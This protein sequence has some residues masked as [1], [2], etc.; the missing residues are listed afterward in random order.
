MKKQNSTTFIK[1]LNFIKK[2]NIELQLI[3][4]LLML[5]FTLVAIRIALTSYNSANNQFSSNSKKSDSIFKIQLNKERKAD[6]KSDSILNIQMTNEL[7]IKENL[8]KIKDQTDK[9]IKIIQQQVEISSNTFKD[10]VNSGCPVL[11]TLNVELK[12]T[13]IYINGAYAPKVIVGIKNTGKRPADSVRLRD[14]I[15]TNNYYLASTDCAYPETIGYFGP[16]EEFDHEYKPKFDYSLPFYFCMEIAYYD[17]LT[18]RSF[19]HTYIS[20]YNKSREK[21]GFITCQRI[22]IER[23]TEVINKYLKDF[24]RP[25]LRED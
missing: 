2:Y 7:L 14:F 19:F 13:S 9:Q 12:D 21:N 1:F 16:D 5:L 23:I 6:R 17:K 8:V 18:K 15:L 4:N 11:I 25:L 22:K 10:M 24:K 3:V 20:E